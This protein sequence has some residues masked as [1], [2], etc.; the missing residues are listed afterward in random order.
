MEHCSTTFFAIADTWDG[1]RSQNRKRYHN[2]EIHH[3]SAQGRYLQS[4]SEFQ[5]AQCCLSIRDRIFINEDLTKH[6]SELLY[7]LRKMPKEEHISDCWTY[8]GNTL[9]KDTNMTVNQVRPK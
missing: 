2:R 4:T 9:Y 5:S 3:R 8:N 7:E 6:R 1:K